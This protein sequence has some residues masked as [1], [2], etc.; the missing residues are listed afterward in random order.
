MADSFYSDLGV[1]FD[2]F[3]DL[4]RVLEDGRRYWPELV[5]AEPKG[6]RP[7]TLDV[8]VPAGEGPFPT[9]V[10][11]HGGAWRMGHP[12][13][14]NAP[15][16]KFDIVRTLNEAGYAVARITYRLSGEAIFPTQLH[17]CKAGVRYL[18]AHAARLGLDSERFASMGESAGGHLAAFL[19]VTGSHPELEG[20]VGLVGPSSAVQAVVDWYGPTDLLKMDEQ[21]PS[22]IAM[23]HNVPD[24]PE[25]ALVGG[26]IQDVPDQTNAASPIS[27]VHAGCP[28]FLIQHGAKDRLVPVGQ[29]RSLA[30]TLRAAGV[31]VEFREIDGADHCFWGVAGETIMPEVIEFLD[32]RLR[33]R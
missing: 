24:S 28:P 7:L 5:F 12:R 14:T 16:A 10:Y 1:N 4:D 26:N 8:H 33:A 31:I 17:D 20:D 22:E 19:G 15:L 23:V 32:R 29:G 3:L 2:E 30:E 6:F 27:Y 13:I 21:R 25:S 18:R 11:I 9:V